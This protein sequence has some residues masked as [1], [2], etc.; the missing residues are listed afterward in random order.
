[1]IACYS[2][3]DREK[4]RRIA[5][6]HFSRIAPC[7]ETG[8]PFERG[9]FWANEVM[10]RVPLAE[11]DWL[12]D[13]GCGTGLFSIPFAAALPCA[14]IG[15]DPS[16]AMLAQA[17]A[18]ESNAATHWVRGQ[19]EALP[20]ADNIQVIFLSQVWHHLE[21]ET[22]ATA[23]FYRVLKPGGGLFIKTFS[24]AQIRARWDIMTVFPELLPFMLS[25]YPDIP[26]MLTI[27]RRAGFA[28][29]AHQV[30]CR[31]DTLRPSTLLKVTE[32]RL[33]SMFAYISEEGRQAG[34]AYLRQL[35]AQTGDEPIPNDDAHLLIIARK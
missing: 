31:Q 22:R 32:E 19:G 24:H 25:I 26:D 16:P 8:R 35:I 10:S 33:W 23:E 21:D 13:V 6:D 18:K 29:V 34:L 15:I 27:L 14:V 30:Y 20:F 3:V 5:Q 4:W 28:D 9:P 1:M 17:A 12:L 2:G 11:S 7:Y